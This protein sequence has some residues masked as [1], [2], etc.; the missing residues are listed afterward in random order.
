[1]ERKVVM[2]LPFLVTLC[3]GA[4]LSSLLYGEEKDFFT[5]D[6]NGQVKPLYVQ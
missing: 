5:S 1:M 3:N 6:N 2:T 4:D